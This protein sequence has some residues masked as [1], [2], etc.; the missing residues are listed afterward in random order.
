MI[1]VGLAGNPNCGKTSLFNTI[2]GMLQHVGN[3]PGKTVEKKEGKIKYKNLEINFIDLPGTYSLQPYSIEEIVTRDFLI[4]DKPDFVINIVDSTN[5]ERNLILTLQLLEMQKNVILALNMN[6]DAKRKGITID[7]KKLSLLLGIPV[8]KVEAIKKESKEKIIETIYNEKNNVYKNKIRYNDRLEK[9]IDEITQLVKDNKIMPNAVPRWVGIKILENDK[10]IIEQL[11]KDKKYS[12]LLKKVKQIQDQLV[13][14]EG[15]QID[16]IFADMRY[17][18]ISGLIKEC[19]KAPEIDKKRRSDMIDA[20]VT[21]KY[22]GFPIF[23]FI[24]FL[25]FQFTFTIAHPFMEFI[26]ESFAFLADSVNLFI[27]NIN[28]PEWV[29]SLIADGF[30]GGVGS[31]IVF[32]PNIL[33]LFFFIAVLEDSG[34]MARAAFIMDKIMHKIGLHGKSFIPLLLGFGC[35]VPA[36]M[37]SRT[38]QSRKDRI[39][40]ILITPFMSCS[41]R[42]PVYII[43]VAAFFSEYEGLILFSLYLFGIL[44]AVIMGLIFKN[45]LF[46]GMTSPFVMELPPYRI[47]KFKSLIIHTWE[48][49]KQ[50]L[51]KAGTVIFAV[52]LFIWFLANLPLGVEYASEQ[53]VIGIIGKTIAPIFEPLG[54]G[55]WQNSVALIFGILAKEVVIGTFGTLYGVGEEGLINILAQNFTPLSAISFMIFILLYIPCIPALLAIKKETGSAKWMWFSAFYLLA[56]AWIISFIVYQGGLL[57]GFT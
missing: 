15:E 43:L 32:L 26:E 3:W 2:T 9:Y 16:S 55:T 29:G 48:N 33:L 25:M 12:K 46:K 20:V 30:I 57:L 47:P 10:E 40:T 36:I 56:V 53:S 50:F 17:G 24:M 44:I 14:E 28:A 54:F 42:L 52:V 34:Y 49:G 6:S 19:V 35:N 23:L 45:T 11:K 38:L 31:V 21:N 7:E 39:L 4:N 51:I 8:I 18:F 22:A 13:I 37:A 1:K 27:E 41:A 5:L